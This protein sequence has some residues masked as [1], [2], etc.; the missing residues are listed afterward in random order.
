MAQLLRNAQEAG[1]NLS[2]GVYRGSRLVGYLIAYIRVSSHLPK[3]ASGEI[4]HLHDVAF[5]PKYRAERRLLLLKA[6]RAFE[7]LAP[8][9]PVEAFVLE[10]DLE[11]FVATRKQLSRFGYRPATKQ[12]TGEYRSGYEIFILRWEP[13]ED[14]LHTRPQLLPRGPRFSYSVDGQDLQVELVTTENRWLALKPDWERLVEAIPGHTVFHTFDFQWLWWRYLGLSRELFIV[15]VCDG[16]EVLAIAPL[17][18]TATR[19]FG[20]RFR[21]LGLIGSPWEVDRGRFLIPD[22]QGRCLEAILAFLLD[23][24]DC[25]D[26]AVLWEQSP[27]DPGI[28]RVRRA[29]VDNGFITAINRTEPGPYLDLAGS[30]ADYLA[31]RSRRLRKNLR[32]SRKRLELEG[33]VEPVEVRDWPGAV[34]K[35]DDYLTIELK[36]WKNSRGIGIGQSSWHFEFFKALADHFSRTGQFDLRFLELDGKPIAATFGLRYRQTFYS[37]RIVHDRAYDRFSPGTLLEAIELESLFDSGLERYD[38][39]GGFLANK[40]R[41]TETV[42]EIVNLHAFSRNWRLWLFHFTYFRLKSTVRAILIRA[43]VFD[44]VVKKK[45]VLTRFLDRTV[46]DRRNPID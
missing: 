11:K 12:T 40:L 8:G 31:R 29:F 14:R 35:L 19:I 1:A 18:T 7:A 34:E 2:L 3:A 17:M 46:R 20:R 10:P 41:W 6:A 5:L 13:L 4:I 24:R 32:Q 44:A 37:M 26:T 38:F 23:H 21:E 22:P 39:L 27:S 25:W 36:S 16:E 45:R 9:L 42:S 33:K 15:V 30:W 43:G 28:D